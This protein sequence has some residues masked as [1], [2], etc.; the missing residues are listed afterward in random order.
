MPI[1]QTESDK[2]DEIMDYYIT[3]VDQE[4]IR[5]EDEDGCS[6]TIRVTSSDFH[7]ISILVPED[8]RRNGRGSG[9]LAAAEHVACTRGKSYMRI[10]YVDS[11]AM[12]SL[13]KK[14]G[15]RLVD[16]SSISVFDIKKLQKT[17]KIG[18][19]MARVPKDYQYVSLRELTIEGFEDL[20]KFLG[21]RGLSSAISRISEMDIDISGVLTVGGVMSAVVLC[22][23]MG[24]DIYMDTAVSIDES[25][26]TIIAAAAVGMLD[27]AMTSGALHLIT[28]EPQGL[29]KKVLGI[30]TDGYIWEESDRWMYAVKR[31]AKTEGSDKEIS[32][33]WDVQPELRNEWQRELRHLPMQRSMVEKLADNNG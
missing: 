6:V 33:N 5:I 8:L 7:I 4:F 32:V 31:I 2:T 21:G 24:D 26:K 9:L 10:A 15:Y 13:V 19:L 16:E 25:D 11:E 1:I 3:Y 20:M 30:I 27:L 29:S 12:S 17:I 18:Q 22:A 28:D 23:R 14:C